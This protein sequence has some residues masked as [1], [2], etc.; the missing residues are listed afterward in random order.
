MSF[1]LITK[2]NPVKVASMPN[3]VTKVAIIMSM[4]AHGSMLS[5]TK[6]VTWKAGIPDQ[7]EA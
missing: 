4:V 6:L 1:W 5:L 7:C 2:M 3:V